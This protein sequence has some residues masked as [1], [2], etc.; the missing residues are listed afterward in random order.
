MKSSNFFGEDFFLQKSLKTGF[1]ASVIEFG[2]RNEPIFIYL[3]TLGKKSSKNISDSL[4]V[5]MQSFLFLKSL[6]FASS[7][8]SKSVPIDFKLLAMLNY[9][10]HYLGI[11]MFIS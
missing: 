8:S 7:N 5:R 10:V 1:Y 11:A 4:I 2:E 3:A 6:L 9:N